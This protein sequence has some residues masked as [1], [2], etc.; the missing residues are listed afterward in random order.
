MLRAGTRPDKQNRGTCFR[1]EPGI[2]VTSL[3]SGRNLDAQIESKFVGYWSNVQIGF[4]PE[5]IWCC[6]S[7][8]FHGL[9]LPSIACFCWS[10]SGDSRGGWVV[11]T[12]Q[13]HP[14]LEQVSLRDCPWFLVWTVDDC[15][16]LPLGSERMFH[17]PAEFGKSCRSCPLPL[18]ILRNRKG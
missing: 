15:T 17:S 2:W 10:N 8:R 3:R 9:I 7:N 6:V 16:T 5:L 14:F 12:V 4:G 1:A 18:L 13:N 11:T